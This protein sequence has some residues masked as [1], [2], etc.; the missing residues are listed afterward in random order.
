VAPFGSELFNHLLAKDGALASTAGHVVGTGPGRGVAFMFL[1][2]S[3]GMALVVAGSLRVRRLAR[4][5]TDMPDA[6]PDDLLG[7]EAL[8]EK[9]QAA[10][11]EREAA[12]EEAKELVT[13]P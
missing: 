11:R 6:T 12:A 13:A 3:V 7:V 9:Q 4:F 10:A 2:C 1:L 8:A 5:D